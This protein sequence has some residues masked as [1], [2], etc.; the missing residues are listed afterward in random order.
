[1]YNKLGGRMQFNYNGKQYDIIIEKKKIKNLYLKVKEDLKI[2]ISCNR[3]VT[4]R[5]IDK[6]IN[7]NFKT[8]CNMIDKQEAKVKK[9]KDFYY[10]GNKYDIVYVDNIKEVDLANNKIL[11]K[12][13]K[14]LDKWIKSQT[15]YIFSNRLDECILK[16]EEKLPKVNLKIREMKTRW[17]VCN[18]NNNNVTLNSKLIRYNEDVIDYVI[19]HE[20][21]HFTH[22]N[23]SKGFWNLVS[24]YVKNYKKL[25]NELKK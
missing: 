5:Q 1:M 13:D 18:R 20:L 15:K 22:P 2:Y 19:F 3:F 7:D 25:R 16:V 12:D 4:N 11:I 10:L 17:G 9:N 8:I 14:M 24:K 23:H 21:S 6:L